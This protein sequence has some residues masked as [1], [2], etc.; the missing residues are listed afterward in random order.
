MDPTPDE[1]DTH[2][3]HHPYENDI[4]MTIEDDHVDDDVDTHDDIVYDAEEEDI[5]EDLQ[6]KIHYTTTAP[7][8]G[9]RHP[10]FP[11]DL[12]PEPGTP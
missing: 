11:S 2:D 7:L 1:G 10:D 9:S 3:T 4:D 8:R 5:E 12:T 6:I